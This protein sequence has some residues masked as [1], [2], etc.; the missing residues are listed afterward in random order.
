M[1]TTV[2]PDQANVAARPAQRSAAEPVQ[3][4][5]DLGLFQ[6]LPIETGQSHT[7]VL[8]VYPWGFEE[9]GI[10]KFYR[11]IA[12][13]LAD[14]GISS[15]RF[16]LPGTANST[17]D[18]ATTTWQD[19]QRSVETAA[20]TLITISQCKNLIVIG[21]ATGG[22]LAL[23]ATMERQDVSGLVLLAPVLNGQSFLKELSA[24]SRLATA[25]NKVQDR[26]RAQTFDWATEIPS[27]VAA[28]LGTINLDSTFPKVDTNILLVAR[29][30][31]SGDPT[32]IEHARRAGCHCDLVSF[33]GYDK[34]VKDLNAS[35]I[36][37]GLISDIVDWC[38]GLSGTPGLPSSAEQTFQP[39][40]LKTAG[41]V[42]EPVRLGNNHR[43]LAIICRP[44]DDTPVKSACILLTTAYHP[45]AGWARINVD[46]ARQLAREGILSIRFDAANAADSPPLSGFADENTDGKVVWPQSREDDVADVVAYLREHLK[47]TQPLVIAGRCSGA[48]LAFIGAVRNDAI[49][50]VMLANT[51]RFD[52]KLG[53]PIN[54]ELAFVPQPMSVYIRKLAHRDTWKR[55]GNGNINLYR[56]AVNI[57][58]AIA[59][60][61]FH[62]LAS[63][64]GIMT[65]QTRLIASRFKTLK[66]RGTKVRILYTRGDPGIAQLNTHFGTWGR[67]L[68]KVSDAE[69]E[70]LDSGDHNVSLPDARE[71]FIWGILDLVAQIRQDRS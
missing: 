27:S 38:A 2:L 15:L 60:R 26:D 56:A 37:A 47:I 22:T 42:E 25:S 65:G 35:Q 40:L 49:D 19:W 63:K 14:I 58:R 48:Y 5:R 55:M 53:Q 7:A 30:K 57:N 13:K 61:V 31:K 43:L 9:L 51:F 59:R 54:N 28:A 1:N 66:D 71:R 36:P 62:R 68:D 3:V 11:L 39:P 45:M 8:F 46:A 32:Y 18:P 33:E 21:Q 67:M 44:P 20:E 16:E 29:P 50:A 69:I 34:L 17:A 10:R 64:L 52:W 6:R 41:Y 12:E 23:Q 70:F 4:G 24:M